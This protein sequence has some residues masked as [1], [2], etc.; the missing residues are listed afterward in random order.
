MPVYEDDDD[1]DLNRRGEEG[2][3]GV[4]D[5]EVEVDL[6]EKPHGQLVVLE[7]DV[8]GGVDAGSAVLGEG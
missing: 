4:G 2:G 1:D 8:V 3:G 5:A 6:F 7:E